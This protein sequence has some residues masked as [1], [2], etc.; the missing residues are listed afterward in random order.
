MNKISLAVMLIFPLALSA[1]T[2]DSVDNIILRIGKQ[3]EIKKEATFTLITYFDNPKKSFCQL[4]VYNAMPATK[5]KKQD[6]QTEWAELIEKNFTVF[7]LAQPATLKTKSGTAFQRLGAKAT[8]KNG[9]PYYVQLNIYDCGNFYQSVVAVSTSQKQLQSYDSLWQGLI[10][11][12]NKNKSGS[13]QSNVT[14]TTT[15]APSIDPSTTTTISSTEL[16]GSWGKSA[17]SPSAYTNGVLTNLGYAGYTKGQYTFHENGKYIFQGESFGGSSEFRLIDE[18]GT[19]SVKNNSLVINP[20]RSLYRV[21]DG[22][23]KLKK[24]QEIPLT[25]R[26]YTWQKYFFEGLNETDL[27]LTSTKENAIDG[28]F[29][30]HSMFPNSFIYSPGNKLEFRFL[31]LK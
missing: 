20:V 19:Y 24:S 4:A 15:T 2:V 10:T 30:S 27:I 5:N 3:W 29:S 22:D 6:F 12:I 9:N 25:K 16:V 14:T 18:N 28:G 11:K 17:S 31:P 7:T 13:T 1:Q 26:T 21:V 8:D 23:G